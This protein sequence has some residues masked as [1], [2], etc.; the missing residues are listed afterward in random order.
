MSAEVCL[1]K[2]SFLSDI[3]E[4]AL[5]ED[6]EVYENPDKRISSKSGQSFAYRPTILLCNQEPQICLN[7]FEFEYIIILVV[8]L[9]LNWWQ[10]S[11]MFLIRK[12]LH[13]YAFHPRPKFWPYQPPA[14]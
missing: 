8:L 12:F 4:D 2:K 5:K 11:W 13:Y 7:V 9:F 1:R 3:P 14:V 6:T 10:N